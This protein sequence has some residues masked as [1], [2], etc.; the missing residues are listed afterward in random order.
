MVS[1]L[2]DLLANHVNWQNVTNIDQPDVYLSS[3]F[4]LRLI[5]WWL[6]RTN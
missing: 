3:F 1:L 5:I 4:A 6:L 2:V